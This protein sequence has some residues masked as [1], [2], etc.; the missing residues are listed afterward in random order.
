M[1]VGKDGVCVFA[2]ISTKYINIEYIKKPG[3]SAINFAN[4]CKAAH[5]FL[6][7]NLSGPWLWNLLGLYSRVLEHD[8]VLEYNSENE[9]H[10]LHFSE[11]I[12][13]PS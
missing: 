13:T 1:M 3:S 11:P 10:I 9:C 6:Q 5:I 4:G 8:E 7:S 12:L 2:Q